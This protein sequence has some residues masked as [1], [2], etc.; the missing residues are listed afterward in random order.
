MTVGGVGAQADIAGHQEAREVLAQQ[1][2]RL[3]S[4]GVLRVGCRAPLILVAEEGQSGVSVTRSLWEAWWPASRAHPWPSLFIFSFFSHTLVI[5]KFLG[6]GP[7]R[8]H[9]CNIRHSCSHVG[10]LTHCAWPGTEPVTPETSRSLTHH[11]TTAG[12]PLALSFSTT[13]AL[14]EKAQ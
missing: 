10:S 9:T 2:D 8:S 14:D 12:T 6:Q 4:W 7:N 1:T 5:W 3:D 13:T 11:C